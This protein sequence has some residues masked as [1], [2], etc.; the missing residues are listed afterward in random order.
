MV[1]AGYLDAAVKARPVQSILG[2][3][4]A[5]NVT[6]VAQPHMHAG[7]MRVGRPGA[8]LSILVGGEMLD[9]EAQPAIELVII[10]QQQSGAASVIDLYRAG[11][12]VGLVSQD[13]GQRG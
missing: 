4:E 12:F 2:G 13:T 10:K 5:H 8:I 3:V 6:V 9:V 7:A 1:V 11:D